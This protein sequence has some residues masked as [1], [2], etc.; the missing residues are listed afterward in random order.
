MVPLC[1][2]LDGTLVRTDTL[3][4]SLLRAVRRNPAVVLRIPVW[5]FQGRAHLKH[6]LARRGALAV[7][8]LPYRQDLLD[9]LH[10]QKEAGRKIVLATAADSDIAEAV[11][12]HTGCFDEVVASRPGDNL[13]GAA[14]RAR[15]ESLYGH[16][17]FDYA[18]D[19]ACDGPVWGAAREA[20]LAGSS[21]KARQALAETG[22]PVA[23]A[24][25]GPGPQPGAIVRALRLHQWS[26]NL[27]LFTALFVSHNLSDPSRMLAVVAA[28]FAFGYVASAIYIVNDLLDLESDRLHPTKRFRPFASSELSIPSGLVFT[29][30][31]LVSGLSLGAVVSPAFAFSLVVYAGTATV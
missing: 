28:F 30:W 18:G 15:L 26:K 6:E 23:H 8:R 7:D 10:G 27:L 12:S 5:L 21:R 19:S 16:K 9:Y 17:G 3:Y 29:V 11:A 13:K 1:V 20:I 14:K 24:F 31:L 22:T 25:P 4:E 2:D